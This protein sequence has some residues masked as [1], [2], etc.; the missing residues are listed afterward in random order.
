MP[1][2]KTGS[3][4][5]V[6]I[7]NTLPELIFHKRSERS[8]S[9]TP[10]LDFLFA[11]SRLNVY[12]GGV[13]FERV[14][15][16][17][18]GEFDCRHIRYAAIGGFALGVLGYPRTTIDLDFL[19]H[20]DDLNK[21]HDLLTNLGYQRVV[22][23]ENV[24]QY[25]HDDDAWGSIDLIH[26]FRKTSLAMLAR[27]KSYPVFGE[28]RTVKAVDPEDVIGL[29]V[30]AMVNDPDRRPQELA[31]IERLMDLYGSKLD[32]KRIQEY[33]DVFGLGEEAKRLRKRFRR[34]H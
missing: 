29:K 16:A 7:Q 26:A 21:V 31:D 20:K 2:E 4:W 30:Q 13:N 15:E 18:L 34:A 14:L 9:L 10:L 27:V 25:R 28:K 12:N 1:A 23:T 3:R 33:Y 22:H 24:S 19:V 11:A 32:W 6:L 17:L 8:A 5:R